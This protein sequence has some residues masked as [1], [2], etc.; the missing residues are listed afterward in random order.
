MDNIAEH[1]DNYRVRDAWLGDSIKNCVLPGLRRA[2]LRLL[3]LEEHPL[4]RSSHR[5][6]FLLQ[7]VR[8]IGDGECGKLSF[9]SI[10][11]FYVLIVRKRDDETWTIRE[12]YEK[13]AKMLYRQAMQQEWKVGEALFAKRRDEDKQPLDNRAGYIWQPKKSMTNPLLATREASL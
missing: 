11:E 8:L 6:Q 10:R 1:E 7:D 13:R 5:Q 12:G 9:G 3:P 2:G 4:R